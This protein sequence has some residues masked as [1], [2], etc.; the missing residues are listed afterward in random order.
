MPDSPFA[1][2]YP[3]AAPLQYPATAKGQQDD[4]ATFNLDDVDYSKQNF[5][6]FHF[7]LGLRALSHPTLTSSNRSLT[8]PS[9]LSTQSSIFSP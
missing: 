8:P 4:N 6:F 5:D 1:Q 9:Q 7:G 2:Y 3:S